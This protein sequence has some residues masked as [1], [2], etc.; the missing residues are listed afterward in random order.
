M[1]KIKEA[2]ENEKKQDRANQQNHYQE[3][4]PA[5]IPVALSA[6]KE[7]M[8]KPIYPKAIIPGLIHL[9]YS[10]LLPPKVV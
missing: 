8:P 1:R 9:S 5:I 3:A 10:I 7:D 6:F 4:L 2:Q